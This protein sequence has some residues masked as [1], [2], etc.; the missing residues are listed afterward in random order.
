MWCSAYGRQS[1]G[2]RA[3]FL[4]LA[5]HTTRR[6]AE[7]RSR[8]RSFGAPD[9]DRKHRCTNNL[10]CGESVLMEIDMLRDIDFTQ[11]TLATLLAQ[12]GIMLLFIDMRNSASLYCVVWSVAIDAICRRV[13]AE[14]NALD[15]DA[16]HAFRD[17]AATR[18]RA[19]LERVTA[20]SVL[21]RRARPNS[22]DDA[23]ADYADV[24]RESDGSDDAEL[25]SNN[26]W[27]EIDVRRCAL[28]ADI[29]LTL[30]I[31]LG[32]TSTNSD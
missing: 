31:V 3:S 14:L 17:R 30:C 27:L 15:A 8:C 20:K 32:C 25:V 29:V 18:A 2:N 10:I 24:V 9:E 23:D 7:G 22:D 1:I 13:L 11:R 12:H 21:K 19:A 5:W 6:Y 28:N 4:S 26:S 16:Q